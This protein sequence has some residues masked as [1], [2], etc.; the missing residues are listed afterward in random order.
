MARLKDSP[1]M[2]AAKGAPSKRMTKA[3]RRAAEEQARARALAD[4]PMESGG[5]L[6]PPMFIEQLGELAALA[7]WRDLTPQLDATHVLSRLDRYS[8]ALYCIHYADWIAAREDVK[9]HGRWIYYSPGHGAKKRIRNPAFED[10]LT[11]GAFLKD[12]AK[13]YGLTAL[14]R[15]NLRRYQSAYASVPAAP[16]QG[17]PAPTETEADEDLMGFVARGSSARH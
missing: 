13:E 7:I 10:A 2:Q 9:T 16:T 11:L 3:A 1:E 15:L 4:A 6:A 17:T 8:L 12:F 14:T 5:P